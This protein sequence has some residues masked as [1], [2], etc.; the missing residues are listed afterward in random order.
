MRSERTPFK[1]KGI[2]NLKVKKRKGAILRS[3]Y[4]NIKDFRP[5]PGIPRDTMPR[6]SSPSRH[7]NPKCVPPKQQLHEEKLTELK[8]KIEKP[9]V[10]CRN[11]NTLLP[12]IRTRR[13]KPRKDSKDLNNAINILTSLTFVEHSIT[14]RMHTVFMCFRFDCFCWPVF[15]LADASAAYF[16]SVFPAWL[17][18]SVWWELCQILHLLITKHKDWQRGIIWYLSVVVQLSSRQQEIGTFNSVSVYSNF[19]KKDVGE[20]K[21]LNIPCPFSLISF[22]GMLKPPTKWFIS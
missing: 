10:L 15:E 14:N 6:V 18:I 9:T 21:Y 5:R 20:I 7:N 19:L 3:G 1:Y 16:W 8:E 17:Q 4:I 13:L 22:G 12:I 2:N 11:L